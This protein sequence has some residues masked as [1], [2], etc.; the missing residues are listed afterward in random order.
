MV[1]QKWLLTSFGIFLTKIKSD[2]DGYNFYLDYREVYLG[3]WQLSMSH[4]QKTLI[5]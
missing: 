4:H 1:Y 5:L 2:Q 3:Q